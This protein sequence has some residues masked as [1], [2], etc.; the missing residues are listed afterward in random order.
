MLAGKLRIAPA[1]YHVLHL[2]PAMVGHER[3]FFAEEGLSDDAGGVYGYEFVPHGLVPFGIEKYGLGQAMKEK[4]V[5]ISIDVLAATVFH[6]Q[7][8]PQGDEFK[9]IA[10]WRNQSNAVWVGQ[11]EIHSLRDLRGKRLGIIDFGDVLYRGIRPWLR[12]VGLDPERDVTWIRGINQPHNQAAMRE[13]RVDAT[14]MRAWEAEELVGEGYHLLL[15]VKR[16]YPRGRPDRVIVATTRIIEERP[17][18]VAAFLRGMLRSYWFIRDQPHNFEAVYNVERRLRRESPDPDE[19]IGKFTGATPR[20]LEAH[21]FPLDGLATAFDV[22]AQEEYD[23]GDIDVLP[24][25]VAIESACRFE[26]VREAYRDLASR[27]ELQPVLERL[28]GVVQRLGY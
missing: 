15:D 9:I 7:R 27:P 3:N 16:Q 4:S 6:H 28:Q 2:I 23:A 24:D 19:R 20:H 25:A 14:F 5:D 18:L 8:Y 11:P 13:R 26:F 21:P 10:G 12:E 17:D 1:C 22:V